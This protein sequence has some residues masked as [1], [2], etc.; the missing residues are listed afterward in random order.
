MSE[1]KSGSQLLVV[2]RVGI[3]DQGVYGVAETV[4]EAK[5]IAERAAEEEPDLYHDFEIR[6]RDDGEGCFYQ[7]VWTFRTNHAAWRPRSGRKKKPRV[8][9][10]QVDG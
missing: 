6:R 9:V 3:H 5:A 4:E 10:E 1:P 2:V 8:W 7:T